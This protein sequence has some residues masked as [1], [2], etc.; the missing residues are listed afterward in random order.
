M[1][2]KERINADFLEAYKAKDMVK[3]N[4]LSVLKGM[5]DTNI[6][7]GIEAT[8]EN[9][10]KAIKS[11]EKGVIENIEGR[12]SSGLDI[13][14]QELELSYLKPYQPTLMSEDEIRVIVKDLINSVTN[15]NLG[16]LMGMF[17][18]TNTGKKFDNNV[19]SKVIKEEL[20]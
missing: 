4:F 15:K 3:K 1:L 13:S 14:E 19:V 2:L 18:K 12:K 20:V 5:I 7:K 11:M 16:F 17:N 9:V 10:L 6:G 8:D